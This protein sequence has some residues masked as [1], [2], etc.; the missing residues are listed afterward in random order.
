MKLIMTAVLLTVGM[1]VMGCGGGS[2]VDENV[3]VELR[4][5]ASAAAGGDTSAMLELAGA[6]REG[7]G[8]AVDMAQA[9]DWYRKAAMA[10]HPQAQ[11]YLGFML[12]D[13]LGVEKDEVEAVKWYSRAAEQGDVLAQIN[14]GGML[15]VGRGI[16]Q[17]WVQAHKWLSLAIAQG[18]EGADV[19][20][21]RLENEMSEEQIAEARQLAENWTAT[22][23]NP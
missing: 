15:S 6:Y 23:E 16:E 2:A 7:Q 5:M 14:L 20:I 18:A 21:V 10:G 17:D 4:E 13:G 1:F 8:T 9:V 11:M 3:P 22:P 12:D 19:G